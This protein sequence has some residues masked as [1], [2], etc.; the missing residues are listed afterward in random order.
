MKGLRDVQHILELG[1]GT[2]LGGIFVQVQL[3]A[4][5]CYMT[6]ICPQSVGLIKLNVSI[7]SKSFQETHSFSSNI[8]EWDK[9]D[10]TDQAWD[11]RATAL[12]VN[13]DKHFPNVAHKQTFDLILA[14]DVIYS[15]AYL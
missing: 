8:L 13:D 2:G 10:M 3:K 11:L 7:N 12:E 14:S 15:A 6:D 9:H 4:K 1:S 5:S